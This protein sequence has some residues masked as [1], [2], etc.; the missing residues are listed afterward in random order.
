MVFGHVGGILSHV[1]T[2]V[3]QEYPMQC[4]PPQHLASKTDVAERPTPVNAI[5]ISGQHILLIWRVSA[6]V[7]EFLKVENNKLGL[8]E[9]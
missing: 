4:N 9:K 5:A 8:S 7:F 3:S 6:I 2:R 1:P